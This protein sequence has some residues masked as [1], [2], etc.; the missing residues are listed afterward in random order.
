MHT[1]I[2]HFIRYLQTER[3]YSEHTCTA[4]RTDIQKLM[5]YT[6]IAFQITNWE[7]CSSLLLRSWLVQLQED[8]LTSKSIHRKLSSVRSFFHYL[9]RQGRIKVNPAKGLSGPK[10][11]KRLPAFLKKGELLHLL[12]RDLYPDDWLGQRDFL[13]ICTLFE[14][15]LRR[16]ELIG[17]MTKD[18][19]IYKKTIKVIGKGGKERLIPVR[20]DWLSEYRTYLQML[21]EKMSN[22][23]RVFITQNGKPLYPKAVYNIVIKYVGQVSSQAYR[24]PHLLRH[25]F[26]TH[27]TN[28]GAEIRAIQELLGHASLAATQVYT[29]NSID[30]L[31]KAY[32]SAH[33]KA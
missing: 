6:K 21:Q 33:P 1:D 30:K 9:C 5:S 20:A 8:G 31:R 12:S 29:H 16:S 10:L 14:C 32:R 25:S 22:Q 3:R 2:D 24:G 17:L 23:E 18:I 7:N 11:P 26:A 13:I 27:L 28:E 4:Y 15:G 19:D